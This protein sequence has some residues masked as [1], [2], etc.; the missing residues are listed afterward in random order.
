MRTLNYGDT[1][2]GQTLSLDF[3]S[4]KFDGNL[5]PTII[6]KSKNGSMI[7]CHTETNANFIT[8]QDGSN[9]TILYKRISDSKT[10]EVS[11]TEYA[12]NSFD[13]IVYLNTDIFGYSCIKVDESANHK[14]LRINIDDI[15]MYSGKYI[16]ATTCEGTSPI[17]RLNGYTRQEIR[18]ESKSTVTGTEVTVNDTYVNNQTEF[19]IDGN[20]YQETAEGYNLYNIDE[21]L[22]N[23]LKKNDDNS[24]TFTRTSSRFAKA[25]NISIPANTDFVI[26][27]SNMKVNGNYEGNILSAIIKY[28]DD[29]DTTSSL[30][31]TEEDRR[32]LRRYSKDIKSIQLYL[33]SSL[34][35]G[36][37]ITFSDFMIYLGSSLSKAYEPYT[38]G[39]PSPNSDYIQKITSVGG[40]DN[41]FDKNNIIDGS[42]VSDSN[43][44]FVSDSTSKRTD[45]IEIQANSYYYIYSDKTSGNWGAW[46]DKDKNFISGITLGGK[47]EGTVNSP[48]NAKYIAFT[49]SHQG[50]LADYSNIKINETAI[51]IKHS[52][53]NLFNFNGVTNPSIAT[54]ESG[55]AT[56]TW[57]RGYNVYF[58]SNS[59]QKLTDIDSKKPIQ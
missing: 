12:C 15:N 41:L 22:N 45:Y 2:I 7:R 40:Y 1:L 38:G 21:A 32:G 3:S 47:E 55:I 20:S 14:P 57:D 43:G 5:K 18:E 35:E 54:Y 33:E 48:A 53:K 25:V 9:S 50:N 8:I 51:K 4:L 28:T 56:L 29:T 6:A 42:Y 13:D 17:R 44:A 34:T 23:V 24:Y 11:L 58:L 59:R 19:T 39:I 37:S 52:G 27:Y 30:Y 26:D 16:T 10:A 49:I 31:S 46:Y 36:T